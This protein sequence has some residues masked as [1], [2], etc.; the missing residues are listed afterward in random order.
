MKGK[1]GGETPPTPT[2]D[3]VVDVV[4]LLERQAAAGP[5][6]GLGRSDTD[7]RDLRV[8]GHDRLHWLVAHRDMTSA[9]LSGLERNLHLRFE[10]ACG[11]CA[12]K[13]EKAAPCV[14]GDSPGRGARRAV[15]SA[16]EASDR[17]AAPFEEQ[18]SLHEAHSKPTRHLNNWRGQFSCAQSQVVLFR[19]GACGEFGDGES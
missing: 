12:L 18:T 5:G 8:V 2:S 10:A 17:T 7:Q 4:R 13:I 15:F 1:V 19:A 11:A 14:G 3:V 9:R 6:Q 16:C